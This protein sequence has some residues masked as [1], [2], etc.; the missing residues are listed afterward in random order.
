L[1]RKVSEDGRVLRAGD[2]DADGEKL[3][4]FLK[5]SMNPLEFL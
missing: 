3:M 1:G 5:L 2:A 4:E